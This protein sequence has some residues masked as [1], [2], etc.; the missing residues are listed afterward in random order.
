MTD[1]SAPRKD[2]R[3][4]ISNYDL[5]NEGTMLA[6]GTVYEGGMIQ[7]LTSGLLNRGGATNAQQ[8][9]GR[10]KETIVDAATGATCKYESGIFSYNN[11]ES[12]AC[13]T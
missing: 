13:A 7:V 1:L 5:D 8:V 3:K 4:K 6:G 11:S 2:T 12:N 9:L 10:S